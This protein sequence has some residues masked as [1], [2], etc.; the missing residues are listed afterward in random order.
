M[1][2]F[3]SVLV[4]CVS[5]YAKITTV[6]PC[7]CFE[8][9]ENEVLSVINERADALSQ[10]ELKEEIKASFRRVC[11]EKIKKT[12][13]IDK[14]A[15]I[16]E[17]VDNLEAEILRIVEEGKANNQEISVDI[18]IDNINK[19]FDNCKKKTAPCA[20]DKK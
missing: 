13:V 18:M 1:K 5:L 16:K 19:N 3:L 20:K 10:D 15:D 2:I 17:C 4:V 14:S 6:Q 8:T 12:I 7:D 11:P 9:L